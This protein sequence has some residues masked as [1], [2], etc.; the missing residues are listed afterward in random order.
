MKTKLI[1]AIAALLPAALC[2]SQSSIGIGMAFGDGG[3]PAPLVRVESQINLQRA[4]ITFQGRGVIAGAIYA[5]GGILFGY[6]IWFNGK[7]K[8]QVGMV[9]EQTLKLIPSVG[10]FYNKFS[11]IDKPDVSGSSYYPAFSLKL[12]SEKYTWELFDQHRIVGTSISWII[13]SK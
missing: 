8:F 3:H 1:L 12:V 11:P 9:D 7:P 6:N 13:G 10:V 2:H 4:A 5:T